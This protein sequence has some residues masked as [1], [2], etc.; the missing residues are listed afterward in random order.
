MTFN[1]VDPNWNKRQ[2]SFCLFGKEEMGKSEDEHE[3]IT[4]AAVRDND[5]LVSDVVVASGT[6]DNE[7][8]EALGVNRYL[9]FSGAVRCYCHTLA[10]AVDDAKRNYSFSQSSFSA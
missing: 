9:N 4:T 5:K 8:R 1:F 3:S 10:L 2:F 6:S 7:P